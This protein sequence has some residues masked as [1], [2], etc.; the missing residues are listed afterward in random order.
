MRLCQR[1]M[2]PGPGK[3]P[4]AFFDNLKNFPVN[5]NVHLM[6][7]LHLIKPNYELN[8][9]TQALDDKSKIWSI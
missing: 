9:Q 7:C 4:A 8:N 2:V 6:L 1:Q 3:Y 5:Q